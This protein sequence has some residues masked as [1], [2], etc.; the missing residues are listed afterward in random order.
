MNK[1]IK[2]GLEHIGIWLGVFII[3]AVTCI[4]ILYA[5]CLIPQQ[6]ILGN[7]EK[8]ATYFQE[9]FLFS[10]AVE[11]VFN[12]K[13][14][15]YGDCLMVGIM[16]QMNHSDESLFRQS[17]QMAY[18]QEEMQNVNDGLSKAIEQNLQGNQGYY[19]Y[20]HGYQSYLR[21]L[22]LFTDIQ[23]A[24]II[25]GIVIVLLMLATAW[26]LLRKGKAVLGICYLVSFILLNGWMCFYCF[27]YVNMSLI[28]ALCSFIIVCTY[29]E[30]VPLDQRKK[31]LF[32]FF[33]AFGICTCF[34]DFLTYETLSLTI[35]LVIEFVLEDNRSDFKTKCRDFIKYGIAWGCAYAAMFLL[36]W[37]ISVVMFGT[38]AWI[39]IWDSA[40]ERINGTVYMG[41]TNLDSEVDFVARMTQAITKN[42]SVMMP[43]K[44]EM[45][46]NLGVV[47]FGIFLVACILISYLFRSDDFEIES[48]GVLILLAL[49]P[50]LRYLVLSNHAYLHYFFTYRAQMVTVLVILYITLEYGLGDVIHHKNK[51]IQNKSQKNKRK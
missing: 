29:N 47:Y 45:N 21:P 32:V 48:V 36:K 6:R 16:Y 4:G 44:A 33:T 12:T 5:S 11:Q 50:Y 3:T 18:Y 8:S 14:D 25:M 46:A 26:L 40:S 2:N 24:R 19:R 28:M 34:F 38:Q 1:Q 41:S 15:N 31:Q 51:G 23:G 20:W 42:I 27:N 9:T 43:F 30:K 13:Q 7:I 49:I 22:F 37:F 35:P 39:H 17:M 10:D